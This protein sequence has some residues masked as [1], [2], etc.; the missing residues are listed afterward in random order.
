MAR[1]VGG[2]LIFMSGGSRTALPRHQTLR[3]VVDWSWPDP[4][5]PRI[6]GARVICALLAA[7][8]S[9]DIEAVREP[10]SCARDVLA[11]A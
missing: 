6:A 11:N 1:P 10:L 2:G 8:W 5:V 9:W 4:L 7:G 3:A